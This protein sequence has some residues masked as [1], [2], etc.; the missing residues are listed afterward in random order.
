MQDKDRPKQG[1]WLRGWADKRTKTLGAVFPWVL[2]W[3]CLRMRE[4]G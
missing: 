4:R 3:K 1:D 2:V